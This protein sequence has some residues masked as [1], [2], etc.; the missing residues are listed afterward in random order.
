MYRCAAIWDCVTWVFSG[1]GTL[2]GVNSRWMLSSWQSAHLS[3]N[4]YLGLCRR[5]GTFQRMLGVQHL[6]AASVRVERVANASSTLSRNNHTINLLNNYDLYF[7]EFPVSF[8]C[9]T[10]Y[11]PIPQLS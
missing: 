6:R 11:L 8:S 10:P 5:D 3:F 2:R 4:A 7:L 9:S 1:L